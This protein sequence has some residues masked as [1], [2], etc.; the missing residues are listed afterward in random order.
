MLLSLLLAALPSAAASAISARQGSSSICNEQ[1]MTAWRAAL[2][3]ETALWS[4]SAIANDPFYDTPA[5]ATGARPGDLIRWQDVPASA[6][7]TNWTGI[8][9]GMSLSRMIYMTEDIDRKP[10]PASAFILL[11]LSSATVRDPEGKAAFKT[12]AWA[13]GTTGNARHCSPSFERNLAYGWEAPL[14]FAAN[15]YA[16]IATDYSGMGATGSPAAFRYEAGLIHAADVAYSL[17]AAR[18]I[19]GHLLTDE[20]AVLGHSEGGMT[21]WRT[22]ERLAMPGQEELL[23]AGKFLGAVSA[24]PALRP[25]ELI[26]RSFEIADKTGRIG[27]V[28]SVY[29]LQSLARL[30]PDQFR[31][32]D[33]LTDG[34]LALLPLLDRGCLNSGQALFANLTVAQIYKNT[35]WVT[36]PA[37]QEWQ[38]RVNGAGPHALAAPMLVVQGLND[39]LTYPENC[40]KDF[41]RTCAAFP[42][43]SAELYLVP[44]LDHDPAFYAAMPYYWSWVEALFA[45]TLKPQA[46]CTRSTV[47][48]VNNHFQRAFNG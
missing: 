5:N 47:K 34:A 26:P 7:G 28:V 4:N 40:I 43:S 16:V 3:R 36:S 29:L 41:E 37:L 14:H 48:P 27:A 33:Y 38:T 45:G 32:Q 35:S 30:R 19:I 25:A 39:T 18:K 23:K 1:C 46:A 17:V 22:N 12:L 2:A 9:G 21:A 8:P 6:V 24:A 11:P 44:E 42:A 31:L 20:W 13:H 10:I 15:G